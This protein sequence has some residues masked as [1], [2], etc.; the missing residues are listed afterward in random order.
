MAAISKDVK[1]LSIAFFFIFF[2]FNGV[3]QYVTPFFDDSGATAIGFNILILIYG[4]FTLTNAFAGVF[5]SKIGARA[6]MIAGSVV[7]GLFSLSLLG[8]SILLTY[9]MASLLGVAAGALWPAQNSYLIRASDKEDYGK[10]SGFFN[11]WMLAGQGIGL[12]L[13]GF[14]ISYLSYRYAF[15]IWGLISL[16]GFILL[17]KI[18]HYDA[19]SKKANKFKLLKQVI[20]SKTAVSMTVIWFAFWFMSGLYFGIIPIVIKDTIGLTSVGIL[21][22]VIYFAPILLSY[23]FGSL[24]DKIGRKPLILGSFIFTFTGLSIISFFQG[25]VILIIGHVVLALNYAIMRPVIFALTGDISTDKNLEFI[26][27]LV[28]VVQ[29]LS[30]VLALIISKYVPSQ[31]LFMGTLVLMA[32][33]FFAI[34][35]LLRRPLDV[36]KNDI[37]KEVGC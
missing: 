36:I 16:I 31:T 35:T 12:L 5:V 21:S 23:F 19:G 17:F 32:V 14:V 25:A 20:T 33:C 1:F 10:N 13:I 11:T 3:Q 27:A 6:S 2:G 24:S 22:S 4:F 8:E 18:T 28:W 30:I 9:V 37:A 34:L 7:Y 26:S 15:L 29:S